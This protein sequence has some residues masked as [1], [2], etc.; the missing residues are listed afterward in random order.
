MCSIFLSSF[1][2][3]EIIG[4]RKRGSTR[5]N[6]PAPTAQ[7]PGGETGGGG[8]NTVKVNSS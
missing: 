7:T 8:S 2:V 6:E 5:D 1:V 4:T 3:Q